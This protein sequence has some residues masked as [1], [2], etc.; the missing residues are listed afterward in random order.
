MDIKR[1][2]AMLE[3]RHQIDNS[4]PII[5]FDDTDPVTI[6]AAKRSGRKLILLSETSG[7]EIW[8]DGERRLGEIKPWPM[9]ALN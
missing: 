7:Y 2:L 8:Q 9:D 3:S 6:D 1:R 5:L 4:K